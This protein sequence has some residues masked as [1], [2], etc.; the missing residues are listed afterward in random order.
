MTKRVDSNSNGNPPCA[1][2]EAASQAHDCHHRVGS[3]CRPSTE[4]KR[5][6]CCRDSPRCLLCYYA[7]SCGRSSM[8]LN[9]FDWLLVG[10]SQL[11]RPKLAK[12][13][14]I[15]ASTTTR[16]PIRVPNAAAPSSKYS[17]STPVQLTPSQTLPLP[18]PACCSPCV[19]PSNRASPPSQTQ[20]KFIY[21]TVQIM[22]SVM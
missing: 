15:F 14:R 8:Y 11:R 22:Y 20:G 16:I 1:N 21:A 6:R 5:E 18:C 9:D 10:P 17:N 2:S 13:T 4:R 12:V 19:R 3:L 7:R